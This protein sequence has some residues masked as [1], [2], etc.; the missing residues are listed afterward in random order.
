VSN[1]WETEVNQSGFQVQYLWRPKGA[2]RTWFTQHSSDAHERPLVS[3]RGCDS[4]EVLVPDL[5]QLHEVRFEAVH[6]LVDLTVVGGLRPQILLQLRAAFVY[7]R[8]ARL[9]SLGVQQD[10]EEK[11]RANSYAPSE[12][13][14]Q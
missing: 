3:R 14:F 10:P 1:A 5:A 6:A 9:E 12:F 11:G 2:L 7:L 4:H 13:H 8:D